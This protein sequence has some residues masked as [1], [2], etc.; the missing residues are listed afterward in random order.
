MPVFLSQL[1]PI[2]VIGLVGSGMLAAFMSTHDTYLLCW[3]SVLVEDV[4]NPLKENLGGQ[5]L[6]QKHRILVTRLLLFVIAGFLLY[7]SM[8]VPLK[9]EL[10]EYMTV[11]GAIYFVGAFAVLTCG[12]YWSGASR[13][14]AWI[15]LLLGGANIFG[16]EAVQKNI[17]LGESTLAEWTKANGISEADFGL[18]TC[19]LALVGMVVGSLLL[20]DK[21]TEARYRLAT[22]AGVAGLSLSLYFWWN[23]NFPALW[24]TI[25][26]MVMLLYGMLSI[27]VTI[28][29]WSDVWAMFK[30]LD[31][32]DPG[33][34]D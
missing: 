9:Q 5:A 18:T 10:W 30:S 19:G 1:L 6:S 3:A 14:G 21:Q 4:I 25:L 13:F 16:L 33:E 29:G 26:A 31:Q 22:V 17:Y 32:Q 11:S 15:A 28:G 20:P 34:D 23:E 7:W 8:F 2:G 27:I 12:I 24:G